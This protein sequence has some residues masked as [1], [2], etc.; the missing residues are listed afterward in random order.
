MPNS[1]EMQHLI[2]RWTT[3][4]DAYWDFAGPGENDIVTWDDTAQANVLR[5]ALDEAAKDLDNAKT[6]KGGLTCP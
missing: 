1:P 6:R 5:R 3:A 2:L 4:Y